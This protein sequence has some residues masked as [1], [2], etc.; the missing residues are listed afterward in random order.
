MLPITY[1]F[2][3][4]RELGATGRPVPLMSSE[5]GC[6][7]LSPLTSLHRT[8]CHPKPRQM[9][10]PTV[11]RQ[12]RL[13]PRAA[14]ARRSEV[15]GETWAQPRSE[16]MSGGGHPPPSARDTL[17]RNNGDGWFEQNADTCLEKA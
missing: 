2:A 6:A 14:G 11:E 5:L 10:C 15:K 9:G 17:E 8:P 12:Q 7:Q 13:W 1:S 16:D 4:L 3:A